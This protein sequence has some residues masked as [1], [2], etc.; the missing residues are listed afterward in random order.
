MRYG[1][2]LG[3]TWQAKAPAVCN[4]VSN[5]PVELG[6]CVLM[7]LNYRTFLDRQTLFEDL[8]F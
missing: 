6:I 1:T 3:C 2:Y 5:W 7:I 8:R 4:S